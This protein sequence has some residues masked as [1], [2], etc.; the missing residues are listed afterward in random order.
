MKKHWWKA[1]HDCLFITK[2]CWISIINWWIY[3]KLLRGYIQQK[4]KGV[5]KST[6]PI[7]LTWN[8]IFIPL[9]AYMQAVRNRTFENL[10]Q[11]TLLKVA[12]KS[13][14]VLLVGNIKTIILLLNVSVSY[15]PY[16]L[17]CRL[18]AFI[19]SSHFFNDM[20]ETT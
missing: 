6:S 8:N 14:R 5:Y 16:H 13:L 10:E 2:H 12:I 20:T 1:M 7:Y 18:Y 4:E 9:I 3:N 19:K 15:I 11:Y 17:S